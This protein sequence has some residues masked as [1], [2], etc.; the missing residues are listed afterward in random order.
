VSLKGHSE[1]AFFTRTTTSLGY[2]RGRAS[3]V[4]A[5]LLKLAP[6]ADA[7]IATEEP[8]VTDENPTGQNRF[9]RVRP[10]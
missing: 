10:T 2:A 7:R 9:V 1:K 6:G 4:K 5:E 3:F 8:K